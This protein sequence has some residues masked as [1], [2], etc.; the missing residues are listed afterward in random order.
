MALVEQ[1]ITST[2]LKIRLLRTFYMQS[3][4]IPW[5]CLGDVYISCF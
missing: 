5:R 2:F 4:D 1:G 3:N